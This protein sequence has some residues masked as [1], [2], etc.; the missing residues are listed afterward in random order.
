M[1]VNFRLP[2]TKMCLVLWYRN[3]APQP[4]VLMPTPSN[5]EMLRLSMLA[6]QVGYSE[7]RAV[8]PVREEDLA[9]A[10]QPNFRRA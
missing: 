3:N 7:I 6:L 10:M 2:G 1:K 4:K 8:E 9:A 5:N